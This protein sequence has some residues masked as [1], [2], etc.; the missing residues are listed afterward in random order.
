[1]SPYNNEWKGGNDSSSPYMKY[2]I[3]ILPLINKSIITAWPSSRAHFPTR[4]KDMLISLLA[5]SVFV[6]LRQTI[7]HLVTFSSS[8]NFVLSEVSKG[9]GD[10]LVWEDSVQPLC[11][12]TRMGF[13]V[14]SMM[15]SLWFYWNSAW[16]F[17][18]TDFSELQPCCPQVSCDCGWNS[19]QLRIPSSW[20][21]DPGTPA[22]SLSQPSPPTW[23]MG[24]LDFLYTS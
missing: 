21:Y 16:I 14:S 15:T 1:M 12:L 24:T 8:G 11:S 6:T 22:G 3:L 17:G 10:Q 7:L 13:S 23:Y 2:Y 19:N 4:A 18:P 5:L 20:P 9:W